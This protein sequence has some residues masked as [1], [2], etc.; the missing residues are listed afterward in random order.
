LAE[1]FAGDTPG[2]IRKISKNSGD[3]TIKTYESSTPRKTPPRM[4][5][6]L[7]EKSSTMYETFSP[8]FLHQGLR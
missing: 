5:R 6:K 1:E 4:V 2:V 7:G 8:N 3:R